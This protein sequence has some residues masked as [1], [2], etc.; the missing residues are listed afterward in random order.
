M[1]EKWLFPGT[2]FCGSLEKSQKLEPAKSSFH[3]CV[4]KKARESV[5][6]FLSAH[7][8]PPHL[9]T[10]TNWGQEYEAQ[11]KLTLQGCKVIT[12]HLWYV[13]YLWTDEAIWAIQHDRQYYTGH[14]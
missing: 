4:R 2:Y 7:C 14:F 10:V 11:A 5:I 1:R 13:N 8:A 9:P 6:S 3:T 12:R